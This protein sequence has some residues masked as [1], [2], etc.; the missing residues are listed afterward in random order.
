MRLA[1][2]LL[3]DHH[4][5]GTIDSFSNVDTI[6]LEGIG[7][8]NLAAL[9]PNNVLTVSG[10]SGG[11]VSLELDPGQS[12]TGFVF[13]VASDGAGGTDLSLSKVING[14]NGNS[15]LTGTA[16]ND[17]ISGGNGNDT[18][19]SGDGNDSISGGN[20]N[21]VLQAGNGN[22]KVDGGNG[23]DTLTVGNGNNSLGGGNGDRGLQDRACSIS[24]ILLS[25]SRS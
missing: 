24:V 9:G 11:P 20:G 4:F 21:D 14:G 22:S 15:I 17:V 6:D 18:V 10:G 13:Q 19:R 1:S 8:A 7:S 23:N 3:T 2:P 5:G 12:F 16:G 25:I